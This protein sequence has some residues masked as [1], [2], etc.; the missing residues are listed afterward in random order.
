MKRT[1][2]LAAFF[3]L[4]VV[5][6]APVY[7]G[8]NGEPATQSQAGQVQ[9]PGQSGQATDMRVVPPYMSIREKVMIQREIQKR[10]AASRNALMRE[11]LMERE[12]QQGSAG[13]ATQQKVK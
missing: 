4:A 5:W 8:P 9:Q 11:A 10:A 7:A 12:A 2:L 1:F 13:K 3:V 6:I